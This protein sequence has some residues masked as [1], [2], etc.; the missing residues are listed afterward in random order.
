MISLIKETAEF[1]FFSRV[2]LSFHLQVVLVSSKHSGGGWLV[3]GGGLEAGEEETAAA[4]REAWEEAGITGS[5]KRRLG[6]FQV[7]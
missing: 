2:I 6:I 4:I 7:R 3:P 1:C 5:I